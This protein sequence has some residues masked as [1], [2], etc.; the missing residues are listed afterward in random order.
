[1]VGRDGDSFEMFDWAEAFRA[2]GGWNI[3]GT[4]PF[5][6]EVSSPGEDDCSS[7]KLWQPESM[8]SLIFNWETDCS[9]I[10]QETMITRE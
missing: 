3:L 1:M 10:G 9:H 8:W 6:E 2:D 4:G 5:W 7:M